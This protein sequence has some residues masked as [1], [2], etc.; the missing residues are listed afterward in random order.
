MQLFIDLD[1][2]MNTGKLVKRAVQVKG[3]NGK[4]FTRMQ[5]VNPEEAKAPSIRP[6]SHEDV[7]ERTQKE[8]IDEHVKNMSREDKYKHLQDHKVEW[9]RNEKSEAIDHKNAVMALKNHL[10]QNPHLAGAEHLP[11]E[12]GATDEEVLNHSIKKIHRQVQESR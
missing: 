8:H 10:Y 6:Q 2:A 5:W 12:R 7:P 9:K 4:I 3:K 11:T 1:K